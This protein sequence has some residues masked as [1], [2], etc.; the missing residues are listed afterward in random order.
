MPKGV[1]PDPLG[2]YQNEGK[3]LLPLE[4]KLYAVKPDRVSGTFQIEHPNRTDAYQPPL[5]HNNH[6]AW[7]T[8]LEQPLNWDREKV[9]R[10]LGPS[11]ESFTSAEREQILRVSG[12]HDNVVREMHV[13]HYRPP[14]LLTDTIKRFR[15][16]RDIE[17]FI[18]QIGSEGG[19]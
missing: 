10:R 8:E 11:V 3:T 13:E 16:N 19:R 2:L 6:G 4:G 5:L 14:S 9:M 7:H 18:E 12:Y 17:T 1:K 15:I